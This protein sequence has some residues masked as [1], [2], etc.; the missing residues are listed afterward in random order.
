MSER[1]RSKPISNVWDWDGTL[2]GDKYLSLC[3]IR[4]FNYGDMYYVM[5]SDSGSIGQVGENVLFGKKSKDKKKIEQDY[6]SVDIEL[7]SENFK[8]LFC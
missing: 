6:D 2:I 3:S 5:Q 7:S 1:I 8:K 4:D